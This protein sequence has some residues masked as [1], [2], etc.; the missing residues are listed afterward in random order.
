[1]DRSFD[2][3]QDS[4]SKKKRRPRSSAGERNYFCGCGKAYL[5]YPALY[6]HV[7]NKHDGIFPIGSNA[8][9]KIPRHS[10][11]DSDT[12]F[13]K[14]STGFYI[15]FKDYVSQIEDASSNEISE[16]TKPKLESLFSEFF[17]PI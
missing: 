17:K 13:I 9:W 5:S 7:K 1:M 2:D 14:D 3:D 16:L 10:D 15:D 6:T 4:Q 11:D 8:K 12:L